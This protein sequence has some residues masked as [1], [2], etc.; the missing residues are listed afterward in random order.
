MYFQHAGTDN[1]LD[2]L[3]RSLETAAERNLNFIVVASNTGDT[4]YKA[5]ELDK[6][7][8]VN[9]VGVTHQIG[10]KSPG[11][12][13][14][15]PEVREDLQQKGVRLLTAT[16]LFGGVDRALRK[17]FGGVFPGEIMAQ[18]LRLFGQ[19]TKVAVE[20]SVMALDAGLIPYGQAVI[21]IGGT[22]RGSDTALIISPAH[23][24][25]VFATVVHEVICMPYRKTH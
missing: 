13:E 16:H 23:S 21:S 9:W 10:F 12:D 25:N 15:A 6:Q 17:H 11:A 3:R 24:D 18:S 8:Q 19:G 4:L 1:T 14:M 20:V 5:L 22:V 7:R 2:T